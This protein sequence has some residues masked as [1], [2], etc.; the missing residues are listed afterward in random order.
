MASEPQ[1]PAQPEPTTQRPVSRPVGPAAAAPAPAA[2]PVQRVA[3]P[4]SN[5]MGLAGRIA[6]TIIGAAG[7]IVGAFMEWVSSPVSRK[8]TDMSVRVLWTTARPGTAT[9]VLSVGFVAIVLGLLAI[10]GLAFRS[11]WLTR[12]AGALGI[13]AFILFAITMYRSTATSFPDSVGWGAWFALA[14]GLIAV[15]GGFLGTRHTVA[16]TPGTV[17]TEVPA[18]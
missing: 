8:G 10:V 5:P 12:L 6:L 4:A 18:A 3:R 15:I 11:G 16:I 7:L 17:T 13:V 9:F 2:A 14:A 1:Y